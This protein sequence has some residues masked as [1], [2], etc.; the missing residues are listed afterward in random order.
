MAIVKETGSFLGAVE[1]IMALEKNSSITDGKCQTRCFCGH[2]ELQSD[3]PGGQIE[4]AHGEVE[5]H[6]ELLSDD[7]DSS[8]TYCLFMALESDI[9]SHLSNHPARSAYKSVKHFP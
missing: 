3:E 6:I 1:F 2:D 5:L 4:S 9:N 8:T 7:K